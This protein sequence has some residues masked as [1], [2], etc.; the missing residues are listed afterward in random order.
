MVTFLGP[1]EQKALQSN[2]VLALLLLQAEEV[3]HHS[4]ETQES[5]LISL[6][7]QNCFLNASAL[8]ALLV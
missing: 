1:A 7:M 6:Q 3:I 4:H 2:V 5:H 8:S